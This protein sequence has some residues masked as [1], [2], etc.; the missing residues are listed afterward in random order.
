MTE[1]AGPKAVEDL[2]VALGAG[3][4]KGSL[5]EV[6]LRGDNGGTWLVEV[7][8]DGVDVQPGSAPRGVDCRLA[9]SVEVV[10]RIVEGR[11]SGLRAY[12]EGRIEVEG[13]VGLVLR[14]HERLHARRANPPSES[15]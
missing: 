11:L 5:V 2:L 15:G 7:R 3:L 10:S 13:D 9:G 8:R 12:V 4:P 6:E 1:L 14:M